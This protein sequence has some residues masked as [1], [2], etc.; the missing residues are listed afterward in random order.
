MSEKSS[1]SLPLQSLGGRRNQREDLGGTSY[2]TPRKRT[3]LLRCHGGNR[4]RH[5][6]SC[7]TSPHVSVSDLACMTSA[8]ERALQGVVF[9]SSPVR[10]IS[11]GLQALAVNIRLR[12]RAHGLALLVK[13]YLASRLMASWF[14]TPESKSLGAGASRQLAPVALW[15]P[16]FQ[17]RSRSWDL[18]RERPVLR[19][20]G[21]NRQRTGYCCCAAASW[22]ADVDR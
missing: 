5:R 17:R 9:R 19:C 4:Q 6:T 12:K 18:A 22:W 14:S 21:D 10:I 20:H 8:A 1:A 15:R 2:Q 3:Q 7:V 16:G 13:W 11:P